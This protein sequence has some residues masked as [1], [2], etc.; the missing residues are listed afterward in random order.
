[1][2]QQ[3]LQV[4]NCVATPYRRQLVRVCGRLAPDWRHDI[5]EAVHTPA[6]VPQ[7]QHV[8]ALS[9]FELCLLLLCCCSA[10]SVLLL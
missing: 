9:G 6:G 7:P 2:G 5:R 4:T 10:C 1:M 3:S 8:L